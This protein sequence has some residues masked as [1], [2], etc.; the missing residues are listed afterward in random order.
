MALIAAAEVIPIFLL[1]LLFGGAL[2]RSL[3]EAKTVDTVEVSVVPIP[4]GS[5]VPLAPNPEKC[6]KL[7]LKDHK[8]YQSGIVS[9]T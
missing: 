2:S 6:I 4:L 7:S 3:A 9:L 8:F 1:L 5:G